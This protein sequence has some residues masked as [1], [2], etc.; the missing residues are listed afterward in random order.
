MSEEKIKVGVIG[1]GYLGRFHA[2]RWKEIPDAELVGVTDAAPERAAQIAAEAG[3]RAF[4]SN[5][6]LLEQVQAVSIVV[7]TVDHH[8]VARQALTSGKDILL[9][10]PITMSLEEADD[11]IEI[12]RGKQCVFMVGHLERFNPAV[13]AMTE[14]LSRPAFIEAHRLGPFNPRAANIDVVRDLMI[15]DLDIV[16][17]LVRSKV[18]RISA[19]GIALLSDKTD[20]AN[21]RIEFENGSVANLTASRVTPGEPMRKIRVYQPENYISLDYQKK[22]MAVFN[23]GLGNGDDPMSRIKIRQVP[24]DDDDALRTE[25]SAFCQAVRFRGEPPVTAEDGRRALETALLINKEI[26]AS[27]KKFYMNN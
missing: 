26:A 25:L 18:Q 23:L 3:C 20:L 11:L 16:L 10:K 17:S 1:V 27:L 2:L 6:R 14:S 8:A 9:E 21:A 24:I 7:P 15:H 12:G 22:Q 5:E 4:E 13:R 19:V